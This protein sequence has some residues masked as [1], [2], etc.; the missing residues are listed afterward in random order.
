MANV[1]TNEAGGPGV[2]PDAATETARVSLSVGR[3]TLGWG[4]L[5]VVLVAAADFE[6]TAELAAAF[7]TLIFVAVMLLY[8]PT[9]LGNL[10]T[11]VSQE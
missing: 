6:Q 3:A 10:S 11:L 5:F 7:A 4:V 2:L 1:P 8:G 9:A